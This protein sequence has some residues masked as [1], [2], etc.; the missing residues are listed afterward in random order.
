MSN[1][2]FLNANHQNHNRLSIVAFQNP[3]PDAITYLQVREGDNPLLDEPITFR[4]K[5]NKNLE[6]LKDKTYEMMYLYR[7]IYLIIVWLLLM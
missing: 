6:E 1:G 2:R 4:M 5:M 7:N 3:S